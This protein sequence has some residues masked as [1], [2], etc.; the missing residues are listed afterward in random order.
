[1]I[2]CGIDIMAYNEEANI[3][4]LSKALLK[5]SLSACSIKEIFVVAS[6]CVDRTEDC[7]GTPLRQTHPGARCLNYIV[8]KH[9]WAFRE[10]DRAWGQEA[11]T[12]NRDS[13][14]EGVGK[15]PGLL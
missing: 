10:R 12:G 15:A 4:Q 13:T 6:G 7:R 11:S 9:P 1:M 2:T 5:Q 8:E 3:G 14:S